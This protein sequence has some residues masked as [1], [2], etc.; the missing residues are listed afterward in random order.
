MYD[1]ARAVTR[2]VE[3]FDVLDN[4]CWQWAAAKLKTGYGAFSFHGKSC[5]AHRVVYELFVEPLPP[6]PM[7]LDH[8]C[9]NR[10]C[11]NPDHLEVVTHGENTRR[12]NVGA[13]NRA[14]Q[15]A[16]TH[17]VHGHEFTPENTRQVDTHRFCRTCDREKAKRYRDR[18][19]AA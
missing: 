16:L 9:R 15:L 7:V 4:G 6:F 17:C 8:L 3:K 5:R 11:V 1:D 12:G 10:L 19:A 18:L 13:V 2:L 14:R